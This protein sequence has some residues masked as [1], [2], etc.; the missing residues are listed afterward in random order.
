MAK[1]D[2]IVSDTHLGA[3]PQATERSFIEFL[4]RITPDAKSLLING[5]L[6]DFW[7]EWGDVIPSQH[8]RVLAA[9]ADVVDAGVPVTMIG[10]NHDAWGGRFLREQ[11]G[12]ALHNGVL[13]SSFAGKPALIA[14]GDGLG[15]GDLKYRMLKAVL[16]SKAATW[17]FRVLHPE[18]GMRIAHGVS[19]TDEKRHN[20]HS[21]ETR[22]EFLKDWAREQF[23]AD[24]QLGWVVCGHSHVPL[25]MEV[26]AGQTYINSGDWVKHSTYA[27]IDEGGRAVLHE[28]RE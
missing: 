8:Y 5:D 18:I 4:R 6:F 12:V 16:R 1:V 26:G 28:W 14:H 3:V 2:Y 7:F 15:K 20:D 24:K 23:A 17:G 21:S 25:I 19:S 10:G 13:R 22:S 27:T 9:I 11:V